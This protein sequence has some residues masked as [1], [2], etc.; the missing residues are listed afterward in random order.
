ML[1]A[2]G[3]ILKRAANVIIMQSCIS[4]IVIH[5]IYCRVI[6]LVDIM[7]IIRGIASGPGFWTLMARQ[8]S[9]L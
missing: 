3:M 2:H 7:S 4:Q 6:G 8:R 5:M 9:D 1:I